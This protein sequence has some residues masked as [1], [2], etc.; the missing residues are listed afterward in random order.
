ML[1]MLNILG[2]FAKSKQYFDSDTDTATFKIKIWL[3]TLK[4]KG[5]HWVSMKN[6]LCLLK[7]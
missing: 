1:V 6:I 4:D 2:T 3:N 7:N 5:L